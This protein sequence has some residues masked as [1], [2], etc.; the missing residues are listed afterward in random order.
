MSWNRPVAIQMAEAMYPNNRCL[1]AFALVTLVIGSTSVTNGQRIT[2]HLPNPDLQ[3]VFPPGVE[4]GNTIR[5]K[6]A[7]RDLNDARELRFSNTGIT[8][9]PINPTTFE[10]TAAPSIE[11][12]LYE[13]R[14]LGEH[15]LSTP[16][17]FAVGAVEELNETEP[18]DTTT[19]AQRLTSDVTLNGRS[20]KTGDLDVYRISVS[21]GETIR[22]QCIAETIDSKLEAAMTLRNSRGEVVAVDHS[23]IRRDALIEHTPLESGDYFVEVRDLIHEGS[24]NHFY[25]LRYS[26][27]PVIKQSHPTVVPSDDVRAAALFRPADVGRI[28]LLT[29]LRRGYHTTAPSKLIGMHAEKS[30]PFESI[31]LADHPVQIES[32]GNNTQD[33]ADFVSI[34]ITIAGQFEAAG[35]RDWYRFQ[36]T[37]GQTIEIEVVSQRLGI[38][39][40]PFFVLF[41]ANGDQVE[42]VATAD[43]QV[44]LGYDQNSGGFENVGRFAFNSR[45]DDPA[46]R[47]TVPDDGEYLLMVR[48]LNHTIFGDPSFRYHL[49]IRESKPDFRVVATA[50]TPVDLAPNFRDFF[51]YTPVL[52]V[53]GSTRIDLQVFR[54][55]GFNGEVRFRV[56]NLPPDVSVA[57]TRLAKGRNFVPLVL[58]ADANAATWAGDINIIAEAEV[59]GVTIEREAAAA[60]VLWKGITLRD[61]PRSR[62]MLAMPLSVIPRPP[63]LFVSTEQTMVEAK[64]GET[65][66]L[67]VQ[68][69]R[70]DNF[71]GPVM[72]TNIGLPKSLVAAKP[73]TLKKTDQGGIVQ[74]TVAANAKPTEVT[75][76]LDAKIDLPDPRLA[77][78]KKGRS[79][80][81]LVSS[82]PITLRIVE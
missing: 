5:V 57:K 35:D 44:L 10:V 40:D 77:N 28:E 27:T 31:L 29:R 53:G 41:R 78:P 21:A 20:G 36:A 52:N 26:A 50:H 37:K 42:Q 69:Q 55:G 56:E 74:L 63:K 48:E 68:L 8:A 34:P 4:R 17:A 76:C 1:L 11:P 43:D 2:G 81:V 45:T 79:I 73:V 6:I 14:V 7:G 71:D 65:I 64:Q 23:T 12:G 60:T 16:R 59:D 33:S 51:P 47:F 80:S 66:D 82:T 61:G 3:S 13:C 75:F 30:A 18:N 49:T 54:H 38:A 70:G 15:G 9:K 25:R 22:I 32:T 62:R 24:T 39:A 67:P 58:V 72:I 19:D 46:Y